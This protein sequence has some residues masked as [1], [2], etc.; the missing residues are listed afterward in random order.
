MTFARM[1]VELQQMSASLDADRL[2]RAQAEAKRAAS[3][4][5]WAGR[6][7]RVYLKAWRARQAGQA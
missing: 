2:K 7:R 4:A 6:D 5:K 3:Q 1:A